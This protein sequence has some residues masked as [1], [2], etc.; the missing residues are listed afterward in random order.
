MSLSKSTIVRRVSQQ[1]MIGNI[2]VGGNAPV[3]VQSM[4]NTD[5]ADA[6]STV[7]QILELWQAGSE[8]VRITVNSPEAAAQVANIRNQ[9][10]V[11]GC[12]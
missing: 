12:S 4:T 11:M 8:I 6:E 1:V 9:L 5:T 2:A 10:D 3:V 7:K